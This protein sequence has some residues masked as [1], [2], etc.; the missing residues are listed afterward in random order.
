MYGHLTLLP[1]PFLLSFFYPMAK[2]R[3]AGLR[4]YVLEHRLVMA[5]HLN[6]CLL[7]WEIVHHLNGIK[8]DNRLGNLEL[9]PSSKHHLIDL[10]IKG[11]IG[12]LERKMEKQDKEISLLRWQIRQSNESLRREGS[13][14][15]Q[16]RNRERV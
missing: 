14:Q 2:R 15:N 8:D 7:P 6:R 10:A 5:K 11:Y 3:G 16:K 4:S 13:Y 12:R 1:F 9:L